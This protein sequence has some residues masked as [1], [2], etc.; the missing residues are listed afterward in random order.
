MRKPKKDILPQ[1]EREWLETGKFTISTVSILGNRIR[2]TVTNSVDTDL[3]VTM[4]GGIPRD[5]NRRSRLPL[6]NKLYGL[7]ATKLVDHSVNSVLY[8]Q[9]ATGGSSGDW[10]SE[11]ITS[12]S[13]TLVSLI[14]HT[15]NSTGCSK[16]TLI[17]ASAGAYMAVKATDLLKGTKNKIDKLLLISPAAY[18]LEI[19]NEPYG[20]NFSKIVRAPWDV[21]NSPMF[22]RLERFV[23]EGGSLLISFFEADDPPIPRYIQHYY[24][25][26]ARK[27]ISRNHDVQ[28][29]TIPGV[30]H[31]FRRINT[32]EKGNV[33]DNDSIRSTAEEFVRFIL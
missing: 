3:L 14:E 10:D 25:E 13:K 21:A 11:T 15:G 30:A 2:Y 27:L 32:S 6:I 31:N 16:H 17:G 29:I 18:P 23:L 12:R 8:N 33:V 28:L 20:E 26:F 1:S 22:S 5:P 24:C 19:E 4:V 9:P 7:M